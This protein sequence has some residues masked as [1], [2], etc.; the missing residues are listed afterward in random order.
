MASRIFLS[1]LT[2]LVGGGLF[3][4]ALWGL[5]QDVEPFATWFYSFAWWSYI[6]L[7]DAV[8]FAWQGESLL[9][10]RLPE[11]PK[12]AVA[13]VTCWLIFELV[14]FSLGNW[15]YLGLPP[16][17]PWRWLGYLLSFAT[18]FPGLFQTRDLLAATGLWARVQGPV[19]SPGTG[20]MPP[21][22]ILGLVMLLLPF[23]WPQYFFPLTW[24]A[25]IFL[26]EPF[27]YL[28]GGQSLWVNW[29]RGSRREIYLL[30]LAGLICGFFWESWNFW[31]KARWVYTLPYFNAGRIFEMPV[32][33]YLGFLPFALECAIMYNFLTMLE[34]RWLT[35]PRAKTRWL[36]GQVFFWI[37]MF[38]AI[39]RWTVLAKAAG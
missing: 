34:E 14:N 39:D 38:A 22:T 15:H 26:L 2:G 32:L 25:F 37:I 12:L 30:L 13:S 5:S 31:A 19:R 35:S 3:L 27:C 10:N 8:I 17:L 4:T 9:L 28:G 11:L 33:G 16:A 29:C 18:V 20:W 7:A 21:A 1:R 6:L 23:L 24:L 36:A